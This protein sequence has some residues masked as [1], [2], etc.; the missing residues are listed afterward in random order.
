MM[1]KITESCSM[2]CTHC[3]NNAKP[4]NKHMSEE[5]FK[6]ALQFQLKHGGPFCILTGGEPT[7]H[8][9]FMKFV[10]MALETRCHVTVTTN[11]VWMQDKYITVDG[12]CDQYAGP[13]WQVTSD[14]RYYPVSIDTTLP[15][16]HRPNVVVCDE[17]G[18]IYPQGRA[19]TNGLHCEAKGSKCF[20][21]RAV[22]K[23]LYDQHGDR[24]TLDFV[25]GMMLI[26][27][28]MCT[29]HI[30][31]SG[32]I[33]LGE[34]DLCPVCSNIYKPEKE[35]IQDILHFRCGQCS[36]INRNLTPQLLA[37]IGES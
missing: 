32:D 19:V 10:T 28:R 23:Q 34:S 15:V 1:I 37:L 8:P 14:K 7:E 21:I 17:L 26:N 36:H 18:P 30:T 27:Q 4:C 25:N 11:G 35:I 22:V 24:L 12:L 5:T 20:N 13:F 6:D 29:P 31:V 33:K 3:M 16:F 9:Q 2:G